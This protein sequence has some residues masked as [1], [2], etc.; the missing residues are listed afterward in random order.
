M[1]LTP[2]FLDNELN[3]HLAS[4]LLSS[5]KSILCCHC[6]QFHLGLNCCHLDYIMTFMES[7]HAEFIEWSS[8]PQLS[9]LRIKKCLTL[10]QILFHLFCWRMLDRQEVSLTELSRV[11]NL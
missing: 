7:K 3:G 8:T 1:E 11:S 2:I 10:I 4:L 9:G 6:F 5:H